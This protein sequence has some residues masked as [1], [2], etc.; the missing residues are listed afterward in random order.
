MKSQIIEIHHRLVDQIPT[1]SHRSF[2]HSFKP[3]GRLSGI[4]GARG[5]G[6]TTIMLQYLKEKVA[7]P[8]KAL[9]MSAD[10]F[11][12]AEN[13][14]YE[15]IDEQYKNEGR[16]LFFI[17]EIHK[18]GRWNQELKNIY[19][20]YPDITIVFS[21][22][23]S[24]DL[25]SGSYDLSRRALL[26]YLPGMSFREYLHFETGEKFETITIRKLIDDHQKLSQNYSK[27]PRL[28]GHF[29][30][31]LERGYYPF[32]FEEGETFLRR[33]HSVIE[34]TIYEDIASYYSLRTENITTLRKMITFFTTIQ[35]GEISINGISKSLKIDNKTTEKFLEIL[36]STGLLRKVGVN[37]SGAALVRT[38]DKIFLNNCAMYY[39]LSNDIGI[40]C[41]IG[42]VR[43]CFFLSMLQNIGEKIFYSK[44]G[45]YTVGN[46]C[47]EIGGKGKKFTQIKDIPDSYL[48]KDG[49]L[50]SGGKR[51][52][53][54]WL[55]GFL[56]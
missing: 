4:V 37:K 35:P 24:I 42:T 12:F 31:Y 7:D 49:L 2:F 1:N 18:Y 26:H 15:F 11:F 54:L 40:D 3:E 41:R 44:K 45:D 27:L 47:F 19:D 30:N 6:K 21:G 52:I 22:S 43:E 46:L 29:K 25:I 38:P 34:K 23:S 9:Y 56:Y 32:A 39:A 16:N 48:V 33:L 17:D 36:L 53:P 28:L 50:L 55:F 14:L 8:S 10:H 51:E 13:S 5:T 20:S